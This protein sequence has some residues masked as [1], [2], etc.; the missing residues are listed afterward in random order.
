MSK[1]SPE[2]M[3]VTRWPAAALLAGLWLGGT[4]ATQALPEDRSQPIHISADKALRD[5]KQGF[6]VYE[7]NVR[8]RQGTLQIAAQRITV[9]HQ[10]EEADRILAEGKPARMQQQPEADQGLMHAQADT[11]EYFKTEER[12][13]LQHNASIEQDGSKV[14]GDSIEYL[15][16]QQLIRADSDT[17][18]GNTG[19]G[20]VEVVIPARALQ[21][22]SGAGDP[23]Q[24][25]ANNKQGE[26]QRGATRSQ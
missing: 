16:E 25:A 10:V 24:P 21:E 11:I 7:G 18:G 17:A 5:E 26:D 3:R 15:I 19:G 14:A 13:L 23:N 12:V 1:R 8:M 20:Q 9:F 2:G 6:T 4:A 22:R